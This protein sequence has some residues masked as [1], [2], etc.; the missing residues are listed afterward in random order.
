MMGIFDRADAAKTAFMIDLNVTS[1]S[2]LTLAF[3]PGMVER[4]RGGILNISSGFG[5]GIL[6]TF[7]AYCGTK[8]FVTGFTE[9]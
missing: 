7:A 5:L 3:L 4:K 6:P 2:L 1:L 9:G 8:H